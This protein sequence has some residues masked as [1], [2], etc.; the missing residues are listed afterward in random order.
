MIIFV[1]FSLPGHSGWV[2]SM[3]LSFDCTRLVTGG[4]DSFVIIWDAFDGQML[5][6]CI[7]DAEI[8]CLSMYPLLSGKKGF[9][10]YLLTL[11]L[12]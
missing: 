7:Q 12:L 4:R 9:R 11:L 5:R 1:K 3:D 2:T 6:K 10:S 8:T